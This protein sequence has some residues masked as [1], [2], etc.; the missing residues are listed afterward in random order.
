MS[1][2]FERQSPEKKPVDG[3][4]DRPESRPRRLT[5]WVFGV[6]IRVV[7]ITHGRTYGRN[8]RAPIFELAELDAIAD[9]QQIELELRKWIKHK[10]A[11][12]QYVQVAGAVLFASVT[13]CLQWDLSGRH[14]TGAAFWYASILL[15][16]F[17]IVL[18]AQQV[19]VLDPL[20][21]EDDTDWE[22]VRQRLM[23]QPP[24]DGKLRPR[25]KM[26]YV[27]QEPLMTMG[28]SVLF[29]L[30]GLMSHVFSPIA[31]NPGWN[32]SSKTAV[33]FSIA[34][35]MVGFNFVWGS[36]WIHHIADKG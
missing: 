10:K 36:R 20:E 2:K 3:E 25:L 6:I 23:V 26:L 4:K 22:C 17:S 9:K 19:L 33:I 14:W 24:V 30:A 11:E 29:F 16:L 34:I 27:W 12:A 13:G 28:Y 1:N 32:D 5:Q 18:G 15:S 31:L 21:D 7:T 35:V 8:T